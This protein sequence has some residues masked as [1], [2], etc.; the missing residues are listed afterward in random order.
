MQEINFHNNFILLGE[1]FLKLDSNDK[2]KYTKALNE[3]Y[4]YANSLRIENVE[5]RD[6]LSKWQDKVRNL[7]NND[8]DKRVHIS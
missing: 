3:I 7:I 4:F 5:T 1:Y 8:N 6:N 2:E